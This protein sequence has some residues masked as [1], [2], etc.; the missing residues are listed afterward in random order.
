M[1]KTKLTGV[2]LERKYYIIFSTSTFSIELNVL[3]AVSMRDL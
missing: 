3:L 1:T 2:V